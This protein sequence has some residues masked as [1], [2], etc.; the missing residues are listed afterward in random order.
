MKNRAPEL[1]FAHAN[2]VRLCGTCQRWFPDH[3][4]NVKYGY[5]VDMWAWALC[6]YR[7][8][9]GKQLLH[10]SND[11]KAECDDELSVCCAIVSTLG[12][13]SHDTIEKLKWRPVLE[14]MR[15]LLPR[16]PFPA[17]GTWELPL[18]RSKVVGAVVQRIL[19]RYDPDLRPDADGV[20]LSLRSP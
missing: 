14:A 12:W 20:V 2:R 19:G 13:P 1:W 10:D 4:K 8:I 6:Q 5:S 18:K 7:V 11:L 17:Q 9:T 3:H 16:R 15:P